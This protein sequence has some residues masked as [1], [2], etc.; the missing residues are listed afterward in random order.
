[1]QRYVKMSRNWGTKFLCKERNMMASIRITMVMFSLLI[2]AAC[3]AAPVKESGVTE[4]QPAGLHEECAS[5]HRGQ[6]IVYD[7]EA[8]EHV[9]FNIHYHA[10]QKPN[11][12]V[13][14]PGIASDNGKYEPLTENIY[15]LMWTNNNKFPVSVNIGMRSTMR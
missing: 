5:M 7:F 2:L 12:V 6:T 4:I 3:A 11:Y 1:M 15:C 8:S 9:D 10:D 14:K 13:D